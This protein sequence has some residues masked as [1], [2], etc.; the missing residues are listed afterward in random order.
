MR[1][2]FLSLATT[3]VQSA[4][5]SLPV[6]MMTGFGGSKHDVL[7]GEGALQKVRRDDQAQ[8]DLRRAFAF[9]AAEPPHPAL[10]DA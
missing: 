4:Q 9:A 5:S 1:A 10:F 6:R 7:P 2:K 8:S 3:N